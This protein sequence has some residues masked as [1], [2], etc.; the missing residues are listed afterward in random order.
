MDANELRNKTPDQLRDEL[1]GLKKRPLTCAFSRRQGRL[2]IQPV[3]AQLSATRL[4]LK[5][6]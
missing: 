1:A 2:K 3:C 4:V 5:R 6:S